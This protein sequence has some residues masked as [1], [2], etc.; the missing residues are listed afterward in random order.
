MFACL[1]SEQGSKVYQLCTK[2][3][4]Q[5]QT[6]TDEKSV[7]LNHGCFCQLHLAMSESIIQREGGGD[8]SATANED[9]EARGISRPPTMQKT[10]SHNKE[11]SDLKYQ[12]CR[13]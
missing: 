11:S 13:H 8:G 2:T 9:V 4:L 3:L 12:Q 1:F 5:S 7:V 6:V 10:V